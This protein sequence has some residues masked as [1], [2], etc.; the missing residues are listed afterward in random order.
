M[1]S[2]DTGCQIAF[3]FAVVLDGQRSGLSEASNNEARIQV[4]GKN[5]VAAGGTGGLDASGLLVSL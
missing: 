4:F 5:L 2:I 3:S 1:V